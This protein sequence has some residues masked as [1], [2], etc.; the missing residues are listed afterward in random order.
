MCRLDEKIMADD[1]AFGWLVSKYK[2]RICP[3]VLRIVINKGA[4]KI[5]GLKPTTLESKMKKLGIRKPES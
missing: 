5:V 4:A 2:G 3:A 1:Q